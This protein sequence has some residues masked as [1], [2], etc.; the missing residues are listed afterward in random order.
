[1]EGREIS[2]KKALKN[3]RLKRFAIA[4]GAIMLATLLFLA[5]W[6]A[7]WFSLGKN[8]RG[9]LWAVKTAKR[10]FYKDITEEEIY[11]EVFDSLTD[12]L[13]PYSQ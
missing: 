1:M 6:F 4:I 11:E 13:D 10:H 2:E 5:G 3:K 7:M 12:A 9:F 8:A